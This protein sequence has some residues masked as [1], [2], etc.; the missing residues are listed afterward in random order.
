MEAK[1]LASHR[2]FGKKYV[3]FKCYGYALVRTKRLILHLLIHNPNIFT[4]HSEI[5]LNIIR[6]LSACDPWLAEWTEMNGYHFTSVLLRIEFKHL[7]RAYFVKICC[8]G[9][10]YCMNLIEA[11]SFYPR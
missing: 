7:L 4:G 8:R 9:K 11:S 10:D 3:V 6:S 5:V 1:S 2:I